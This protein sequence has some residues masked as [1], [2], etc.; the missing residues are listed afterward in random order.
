MKS[1][2]AFDTQGYPAPYPAPEY[3]HAPPPQMPYYYPFMHSPPTIPMHGYYHR[4]NYPFPAVGEE[5][6]KMQAK[7]RGKKSKKASD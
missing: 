1:F 7:R 6:G 3:Y 2:D 5:L 4:A